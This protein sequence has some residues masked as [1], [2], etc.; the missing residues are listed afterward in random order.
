MPRVPKIRSLHIFA[1]SPEKQG[2]E[3][4]LFPANKYESFLLENFLQVDSITLDLLSQACLMYPKRVYNIFVI[5][6]GKLEGWT[7]YFSNR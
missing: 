6:Q 7:W 3:V 2:G 4:K 5:S 1:I